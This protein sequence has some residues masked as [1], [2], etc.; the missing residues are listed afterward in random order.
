MKFQTVDNRVKSFSCSGDRYETQYTLRITDTGESVFVEDGEIDLAEAINSYKESTDIHNILRKYANGDLS[1]LN[2]RQ[3]SYADLSVMP[4]TLAEFMQ[5]KI[6]LENKF[7]TLPVSER[8]S[9]DN[10]VNKFIASYGSE[11]FV[12]TIAAADG[13]NISGVSP[14]SEKKES[15]V[16]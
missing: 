2:Q 12:R 4:K 16:E 8:Q 6:D 9:Y 11:K 7:S 13:I 3:P 5:L 10:D 14:V 15:E 1:V